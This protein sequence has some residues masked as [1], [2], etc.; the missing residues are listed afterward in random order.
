MQPFCPRK[1]RGNEY[2]QSPSFESSGHDS[3]MQ[4]LRSARTT[5]SLLLSKGAPL[6]YSRPAKMPRAGRGS[7][8]CMYVCTYIQRGLW[9]IRIRR[10]GKAPPVGRPLSCERGFRPTQSGR[11]EED[12]RV[13]AH[14]A[15]LAGLGKVEKHWWHLCNNHV[16]AKRERAI[17]SK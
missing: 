4:S 13:S 9:P 1:F 11:L 10:I 8:V 6:I 15:T 2:S 3:L 17:E 5:R 14:L 7:L 16:I 12:L